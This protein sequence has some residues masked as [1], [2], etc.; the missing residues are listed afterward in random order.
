MK[1]A[2]LALAAAAA[3]AQEA[4]VHNG[5][6][7]QPLIADRIYNCGGP[8]DLFQFT[9]VTMTPVLKRGQPFHLHVRGVLREPVTFGAKVHIKVYVGILRVYLGEEDGCELA[10]KNPHEVQCP[11][12][13]ALIDYKYTD[14]I[15]HLPFG[16]S[17]RFE[18]TAVSSSNKQIFMTKSFIK[19]H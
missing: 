18:A 8:H 1:C 5:I 16:G 14:V 2:L 15:P 4:P 19:L 7:C 3:R 9:N 12:S 13:P 11:V 10:A 17:V 6:E